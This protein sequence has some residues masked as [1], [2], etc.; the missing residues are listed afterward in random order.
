MDIEGMRDFVKNQRKPALTK[1]TLNKSAGNKRS[2]S[3]N[4][5]KKTGPAKAEPSDSLPKSE[6]ASS[7]AQGEGVKERWINLWEGIRLVGSF[8]VLL[9]VFHFL[10]AIWGLVFAAAAVL[11]N[12]RLLYR[13]LRRSLWEQWV[14][15]DR[16][17]KEQRSD[18][19]SFDWRPL[20]VLALVALVL[21][22]NNYYGHRPHFRY[23]VAKLLQK[24]E[25]KPLLARSSLRNAA[26]HRGVQLV[27]FM[28][29]EKRFKRW[30]HILEF[31]YWVGWRVVGFLI[32]P[33]LL[34]LLLPGE[35]LRDYGL[36]PKGMFDHLWIYLILFG[37][38]FPVVLLASFTPSF[39]NHYPFPWAR[40]SPH[41][42]ILLR[43]FLIWEG[44]YALQFLALE[45]FFRG[46]ML[47]ALRRSMGAYAIFAM[48]VPY[49]MIHFGKPIA[50]TLGAFVAG[51]ILGTLS[52]RTR[53]IWCGVFIHVSVAWSMDVAAL[54]QKGTFPRHF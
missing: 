22:G 49:C 19:K 31:G 42:G 47:N 2:M 26:G 18:E 23:F 8:V 30:A 20:V 21:T 40:G 52:L 43:E 13:L 4:K 11:A 17:S 15:I 41:D 24:P 5:N 28:R 25:D 1:L 39:M 33:I 35:R 12:I 36:S 10:D 48:V 27:Y 3:R 38:V 50:E 16:E 37:I 32:V 44:I 9:T 45:F 34:V 54:I 53:S 46:F 7:S 6:S 29:F 14:I 51:L